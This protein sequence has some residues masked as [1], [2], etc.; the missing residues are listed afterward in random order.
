MRNLKKIIALVA[1]FAMMVS[2]VAFAQD[3]TDVAEDHNYYEAI[4]M[5]SKLN[6]L[7]G[8]D[9]DGDGKMD[10][11][12]EDT[13]TRAEVAAIVSRIQNIDSAAQRATEFVDVP[14]T[15][16]ASGYVAQAAGQGIVNGYGDGN[17]G[18]EDN[19]LYEQV[20][21]ML[22]VTLGYEPFAADNGGYPSGYL[23]AASRYGVTEGLIGANVGV[24][25]TRGQVAQL[26]YKAVDT[27]LMDRYVYG[28]EK[29]YVIYDGVNRS[30]MSL[31]TRDLGVKKGSGIVKE[32][33]VTT[34][35]NSKSID[36]EEPVEIDFIFDGYYVYDDE[37]SYDG[38]YNNY[39]LWEVNTIYEA[40][41]NA[42]E[43]LGKHVQFFLKEA[44]RKGDYDLISVAPTNKNKEVS[45]GLGEYAGYAA[46]EVEFYTSVSKKTSV[47]IETGAALSVIYNGVAYDAY[48][49]A[50]DTYT[51]ANVFSNS[52][53][54]EGSAL[55]TPKS[56][57]SGEVTFID[58]DK[59]A[60]YDV[61][62]IEIASIGVVDEVSDF[63][64]ITMQAVPTGYF[65]TGISLEFDEE[66]NE[67]IIKLTKDGEEIECTELKEWDVLAI[68]Y[69]EI[70]STEYYDVRV[71]ESS[72][73]T[74]SVTGSKGSNTSA[75][76]ATA[77]LIDGTYYDVANGCYADDKIKIGAAGT[78]Y[79]DEYDKI[80]AYDKNGAN[81]A[82]D[83][84]AYILGAEETD[85][86]QS[87]GVA[88]V[89]VLA[90]DKTGEVYDMQFASSVQFVNVPS[91]VVAA[92][93][94][95]DEQIKIKDIADYLDTL[96]AHLV[97]ELVTYE[98]NSAGEIKSI[99][100]AQTSDEEDGTL[101]RSP[102]DTSASYDEDEAELKVSGN[103]YTLTEDTVV[104]FINT[105]IDNGLDVAVYG[106]TAVDKSEAKVGTFASI[107]ENDGT[108][109]AVVF[110]GQ[111]DVPGAVVLL[112][113]N[114]GISAKANIA[115]LA[116][117]TGVAYVDGDKVT[118]V[119]YYMGGELCYSTVDAD[120]GLN[121]AGLGS[122]T[123][124]DVYKFTLSADGSVIELATA[125]LTGVAERTNFKA[126]GAA[127]AMTVAA[128][129]GS[130][131][132]P[133]DEDIFFG[134][135]AKVDTGSSRIRVATYVPAVP[136]VSAETWDFTSLDSIKV[137]D[138]NV[139]VVDMNRVKNEVYVG[140]IASAYADERVLDKN[141]DGTFIEINET[142]TVV[143]N[144]E[145]ALGM[146]DYVY[147]VEYDDVVDVVVYKAYDFGRFKV[148]ET[149]PDAE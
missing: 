118:S 88:N 54:D 142:G 115:V 87:W 96:A 145:F 61:V 71:L 9:Q 32:N 66:D 110:D 25:A 149:D 121:H 105:V 117:D 8:D 95:A 102:I 114:G 113:T 17:F 73:V 37:V 28:D 19:V 124:G 76:D 3:F 122:A 41:S 92:E 53:S 13:I 119:S 126:P 22:M 140:S 86:D 109:D 47:D 45:F 69:A 75:K 70:D 10:F 99:T 133:Y 100:F 36:T 40:D 24:E 112:N 48:E 104:F 116:E 68:Y 62:S 1:V 12:P 94:V 4:E 2:T 18:P 82:S 57:Y 138:G 141:L 129:T 43:Y 84:Y 31:L 39:K 85:A 23:T 132:G 15:H 135:V 46:G 49:T 59:D 78:F 90:L 20:V 139:Y 33:G 80:V 52:P 81:V 101:Y 55:V 72:A 14:A 98:A 16:W 74:S 60:E 136:E 148:S 65:G 144:D 89:R 58:N 35:T 91:G 130:E 56:T 44:N 11:R 103:T 26:V 79:I 50:E 67:Q 108:L 127:G 63:G 29:E 106:E 34:L 131:V 123:K 146:M 134:P 93:A 7:T 38:D 147:A 107:A 125:Y 64:L 27:A 137:N 51:I 83:N 21:K 111:D 5:L 120:L 143:E 128:V 6:I 97:G 77:Y 30:Y 42:S